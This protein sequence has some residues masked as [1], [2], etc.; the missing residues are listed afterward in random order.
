MTRRL[1]ALL[2]L[3]PMFCF[4]G[5]SL[6]AQTGASPKSA[7]KPTVT[8]PELEIAKQAPTFHGIKL[9]VSLL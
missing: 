3:V 8:T 2:L 4:W 5:S 1:L 9:G 6:A 7:S